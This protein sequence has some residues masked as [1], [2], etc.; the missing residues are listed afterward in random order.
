METHRGNYQEGYDSVIAER[1]DANSLRAER[2]ELKT[3]L[4]KISMLAKELL[5]VA[6]PSTDPIK[7]SRYYCASVFLASELEKNN[8]T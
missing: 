4:D 7:E 3:K 5:D 2:D 8:R 6:E 1:G